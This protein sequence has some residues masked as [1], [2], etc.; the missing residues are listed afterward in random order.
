MFGLGF[1]ELVL[2]LLIVILIFGSS[3]IPELGRGLGEGIKNF[4]KS[5]RGDEEERKP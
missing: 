2:I 4:R 3:K 5:M 1:Q